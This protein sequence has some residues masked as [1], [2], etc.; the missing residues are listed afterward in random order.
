MEF[1]RNF[2]GVS[3]ANSQTKKPQGRKEVEVLHL[4]G[5]RSEQ[6]IKGKQMENV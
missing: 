4:T 5:P 1:L 2:F 3:K 6:E